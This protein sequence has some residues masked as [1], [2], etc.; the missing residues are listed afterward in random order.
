MA[1]QEI[2]KIMQKVKQQALYIEMSLSIGRN[3]LD[4]DLVRTRPQYRSFISMRVIGGIS[5]SDQLI[6]RDVL[7][8]A[9]TGN[10]ERF[11]KGASVHAGYQ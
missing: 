10:I 1:H 9:R 6:G 2:Q 3:H 5:S 4:F 7:V 8:S 11:P